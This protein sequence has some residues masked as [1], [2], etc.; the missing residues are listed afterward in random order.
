MQVNEEEH[1]RQTEQQVKHIQEGMYKGCLRP[2][3]QANVSRVE[4]AKEGVTENEGREVA[5]GRLCRAL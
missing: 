4:W 3:Q 2:S 1:S 5:R